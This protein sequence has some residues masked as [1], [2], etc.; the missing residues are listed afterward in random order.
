ME[1]ITFGQRIRQLR[2]EKRLSQG[3]LATD[4]NLR[5]TTISG[6]ENAN[7][8]TSLEILQQIAEYF[9]VTVDYLVGKDDKRYSPKSIKIPVL[10]SSFDNP[11][12]M[13][14]ISFALSKE[15]E[16]FAYKVDNEDNAPTVKLGDTL[17]ICKEASLKDDG[18]Y[19]I[20]IDDNYF[21]RRLFFANDKYIVSTMNLENKTIFF[22][23]DEIKIIGRVV[24]LRRKM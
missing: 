6:W 16:F 2:K 9:D 7:R 21:L 13:E 14:E 1:K 4:L 3:Q 24:E 10:Q 17:I 8:E 18:L 22:R 20:K 23:A 12:G 11:I 5:Q 15:G 19:L